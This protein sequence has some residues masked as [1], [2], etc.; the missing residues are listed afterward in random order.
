MLILKKNRELIYRYLFKEGVMVAKKEPRGKHPK[1]DVPN[2]EVIQLM[3]S[4]HSKNLVKEQYAWRHYYWFLT[5]EGIE[6]LREYLNLPAEIVPSTLKKT[7]RSVAQPR[8]A[9]ADG[10]RPPRMGAGRGAVPGQSGRDA[11]RKAQPAPGDFTPSYGG[12][13]G[14]V[15]Q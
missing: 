2:I 9:G 5:N 15:P 12:R 10:D 7:T 4:F 8:P 3:R 1:I 13:G 14:P 11:Y 6:F